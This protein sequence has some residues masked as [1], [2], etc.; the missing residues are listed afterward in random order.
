MIEFEESLDP[1]ILNGPTLPG[2]LGILDAPTLHGTGEPSRIESILFHLGD[3][4]AHSDEQRA[5]GK[6]GEFQLLQNELD[7]ELDN[8]IRLF[9]GTIGT[10]GDSCQ[11]VVHYQ[12]YT[13]VPYDQARK[14]VLTWARTM[15]ESTLLDTS[16]PNQSRRLTSLP[17]PADQIDELS[18]TVD[19]E[20]IL[21][22]PTIEWWND[23]TR[24][25]LSLTALGK[26]FTARATEKARALLH[27]AH[28]NLNHFFST[29]F[30]QPSP[31]NQWDAVPLQ[32]RPQFVPH[33]QQ[34]S[35]RSIASLDNVLHLTHRKDRQP[36]QLHIDST[37]VE[38]PANE[39]P[40]IG[41][42][43]HV[44]N[45]Q[46]RRFYVKPSFAAS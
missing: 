16:S 28:R 35:M 33:S 40:T 21:D 15:N 27:A 36:P 8:L 6:Q 37:F 5:H 10:L 43:N 20:N 44:F 26:T 18:D 29:L 30:V 39:R 3:L 1:A 41:I 12:G 32:P 13:I 19:E 34:R 14:E 25:L 22:F 42:I 24:T 4:E 38:P 46:S 9:G 7:Q 45:L 31:T 17:D 11:K 2:R 23:D